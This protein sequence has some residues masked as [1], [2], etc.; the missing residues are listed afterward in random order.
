MNDLMNE[1]LSQPEVT[2][3]ASIEVAFRRVFKL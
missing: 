2:D 1:F 3:R